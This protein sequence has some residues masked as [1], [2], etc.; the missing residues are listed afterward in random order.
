MRGSVVEFAVWWLLL[1]GCY[2]ALVSS[3]PPVELAVGAV[4]AAVCA[5]LA[6]LTR[7][8]ERLRFRPRAAWLRWVPPML[9]RV[10]PDLWTLARVLARR[11][12]PTGFDEVP[13]PETGGEKRTTAWHALATLAL[14]FSPG[15][16][17]IRVRTGRPD[18]LIVHR[19]G[20]TAGLTRMMRR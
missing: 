16:Y 10:P 8:A 18:K 6:A 13:C 5:W 1:F 2:L 20:K 17:V 11:D 4:T 15:T 7:R 9:A 14:S 3:Y 12:V 19:L